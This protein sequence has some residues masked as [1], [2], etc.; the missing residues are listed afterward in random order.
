MKWLL[1]IVYIHANG[2]RDN[3]WVLNESLESCKA[4]FNMLVGASIAA[5]PMEQITNATCLGVYGN[6]RV[7]LR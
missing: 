7:D 1:L 4:Q 3:A 6:M 5:Q 2:Q